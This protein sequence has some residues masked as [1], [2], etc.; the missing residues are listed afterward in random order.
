MF[1]YFR[2]DETA[3]AVG[4]GRL[5]IKY[6]LAAG[7]RRPQLFLFLVD[8]VFDYR[9]SDVEYRLRRSIVLFEQYRFRLGKCC[10]KSRMFLMSA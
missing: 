3:L 1:V 10:S 2:R 8:V 7:V 9:V 6:P 5:V 4:V